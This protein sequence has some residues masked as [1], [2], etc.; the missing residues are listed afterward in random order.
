M[1]VFVVVLA[2]LVFAGLFTMIAGFLLVGEREHSAVALERLEQYLDQ[3]SA[4][5]VA[6]T[7]PQASFL[8]RIRQRLGEMED[9]RSG[10]QNV[11]DEVTE[12]LARADLPLRRYEWYAVQIGAG[13]VIAGLILIRFASSNVIGSFI[14]AAALGVFGPMFGGRFFLSF[15]QKRRVNKFNNQLGDVVIML[16]N[17]MRAGYSFPQAL[18]SVST[19][20][21]PP[22]GVELARAAREIQLGLPMEEVL[23]RLVER[24]PSEDLDLMIAAVQLQRLVGGNLAE[25]LDTI[26]STIRERVR[27]KDKIRALTAEARISGIIIGILPIGLALALF[28]IAPDY[29]RPMTTELPGQI[30]LGVGLLIEIIG[31]FLINRITNIKV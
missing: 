15:R 10:G 18:T 29:F 27:L 3:S 16:A 4:G 25:I 14:I 1:S 22:I 24:N 26:G 5:A 19:S 20:S 12:A 30:M 13:L 28:F 9:E 31:F 6:A 21:K 2:V 23:G 11:E 17:G 7:A 8:D